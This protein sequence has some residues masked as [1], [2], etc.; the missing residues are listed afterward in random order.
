MTASSST[1]SAFGIVGVAGAQTLVDDEARNDSLLI[2]QCL[3]GSDL[4]W[5]NFLR[6]YEPEVIAQ[7]W[8]FT[9]D[10]VVCEELT[11]DVFVQVYRS[12]PRFESR[13]VPVLHWIRRIA[14]HVGYGY[15]RSQKQ[16]RQQGQVSIEGWDRAVHDPQSVTAEEAAKLLHEL[17]AE[18]PA[19]DR[20]VLTLHYFESLGTTEI[21]ERTGWNRALVKVRSMRARSRLK[22]L[23]D[24]RGLRPVLERTTS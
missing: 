22:K 9:R 21:S 14:T 24:R 12:L 13:G 10:R 7:M 16:H 20:L 5:R 23:I 19:A 15:W 18:L 11:Q 4:A 2:Q 3:L 8:R 6:K 1:D 17:L